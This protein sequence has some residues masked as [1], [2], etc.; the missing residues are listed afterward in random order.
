MNCAAEKSGSGGMIYMQIIMKTGRGAQAISRIC[1]SN[2]KGCNFGITAGRD[3]RY[4]PL[5]WDQ[6]A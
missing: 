1:L 5:K 6:V 2:L 4:M 3:L